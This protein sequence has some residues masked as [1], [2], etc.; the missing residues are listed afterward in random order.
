LNKSSTLFQKL[1]T[2]AT[3]YLLVTIGI[4]QVDVSIIVG[5]AMMTMESTSVSLP[6]I[7]VALRQTKR[8]GRKKSGRSL[9]LAVMALVLEGKTMKGQSL[10]EIV[11][12]K[13]HQEV[14][15]K[16]STTFGTC[17]VA[18]VVGGTVPIPLVFVPS[19][20]Q[21]PLPFLLPWPCPLLILFIRR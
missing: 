1:P 5:T 20:L 11:V 18:R 7:K 6:K 2:F 8:N 12:V 10:V 4:F 19:S 15:L 9:D 16:S 14:V 17:T 3:P 13:N 21:V